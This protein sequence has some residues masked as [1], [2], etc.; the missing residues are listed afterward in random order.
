MFVFENL[1]K[2][3]LFEIINKTNRT[4]QARLSQLNKFFKR[5]LAEPSLE[6]S[7]YKSNQEAYSLMLQDETDRFYE[8]YEDLKLKF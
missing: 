8:N 4:D 6:L 7:K 1:P 5:I 3:V 2:D